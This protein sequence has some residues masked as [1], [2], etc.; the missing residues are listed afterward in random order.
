MLTKISPFINK[1]QSQKTVALRGNFT[2]TAKG[3]TAEPTTE[4]VY[5]PTTCEYKEQIEYKR[6]ALR[7]ANY[8]EKEYK[9]RPGYSSSI[10]G[11]NNKLKSDYTEGTIWPYPEKG[12]LY[13]SPVQDTQSIVVSNAVSLNV[14]PSD[15]LVENLD[16]F[17]LK[18]KNLYYKF[19]MN[20]PR[21]FDRHDPVTIYL[22]KPLNVTQ[23]EELKEKV[24]PYVRTSGAKKEVLLGDQIANGIAEL[25][26][27]TKMDIRNLINKAKE[28][29]PKL[30]ETIL[31]I[32]REQ[33]ETL[34]ASQ[35]YIIEDMINKSEKQLSVKA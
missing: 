7:S 12:W 34:S 2:S 4:D 1:I 19:P 35:Y 17:A 11:E 10:F 25:K 27:P 14:Y 31:M 13:R 18:H 6:N 23:K 20:Q 8:N 9:N 24:S 21:W 29:N 30:A 26:Y 5:Y 3:N 15:N 33:D 22:S 28:T 32:A 16:N